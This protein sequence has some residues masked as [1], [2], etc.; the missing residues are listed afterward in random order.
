M[1]K[2]FSLGRT[3]GVFALR[4]PLSSCPNTTRAAKTPTAVALARRG[5]R[6]RLYDQHGQ[7]LSS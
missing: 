6:G 5:P 7:A 4:G 3:E 1:V 2:F